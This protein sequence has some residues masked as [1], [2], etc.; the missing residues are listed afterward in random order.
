MKTRTHELTSTPSSCEHVGDKDRNQNK[1]K[2][3]YTQWQ[4]SLLKDVFTSTFSF[5]P[6][7]ALLGYSGHMVAQVYENNMKNIGALKQQ[8][9]SQQ[10]K[11]NQSKDTMRATLALPAHHLP[12]FHVILRKK[13]KNVFRIMKEMKP[14]FKQCDELEHTQRGETDPPTMSFTMTLYETMMPRTS[15]STPSLTLKRKK[16]F[17]A[18]SLKKILSEQQRLELTDCSH[19]RWG[20]VGVFMLQFAIQSDAPPLP[21]VGQQRQQ[22]V[23]FLQ[24]RSR[25]HRVPDKKEQISFKWNT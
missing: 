8:W 14:H 17:K 22:C 19:A 9:A 2:H 1:W 25:R 5:I 11:E 7:R 3:V 15:F 23:D 20:Q 4:Q 21:V 18:S 16:W 6:L 10:I 12:A 13:C 24:R